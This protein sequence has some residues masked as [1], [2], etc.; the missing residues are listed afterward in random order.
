[1]S[2]RKL[3]SSDYIDSQG[4]VL[5]DRVIQINRCATV[6]KG[7]RRFSFSALVAVGDG[8]GV[9]G[10]GFGK[11]KGVPMAVEKGVKNASRQCIRV[12]RIDGRTFPHEIEG[13]F[14]STHVRLIPASPGTGVIACQWV[15]S[16]L[17]LAGIH[18]CLTKVYGS[19]NPVNVVKAVMDGLLR[20]RTK[21]EV[22]A[23]RGVSLE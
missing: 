17:E 3:V 15:R 9:V 22:A 2:S 4:L 7:G 6:V 13:V 5:N 8:N 16:V 14:C 19:T 20:L 1:M 18:D 12:P 11:A 21:D 23:L 10:V